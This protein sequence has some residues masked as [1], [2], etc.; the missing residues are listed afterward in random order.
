MNITW[1]GHNTWL[2][3]TGEHRLLIDPFFSDSPTAPV[4]AD[5]VEANFMLISHG[6]FDHVA[7]AAAIAKRTGCKVLAAFEIATWLGRQGVD[8][9]KLVG[10]NQGGGVDMPFGR[11][12]QT[13][14][15]HSSSLPDGSYAGAAAGWLLELL[16]KR[17]YF[18]CDTALFGDMQRI[19]AAGLDLAV[20]PIG[21]RFT[22]GPADS[23]EATRLLLPAK[24][25]PCH[26]NTWPPIAQDAEAWAEDIRR[27]T[28][29]EP[30][31][32]EPGESFAL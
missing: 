20:L 2:I 1:Y 25:A 14:A 31:V 30:V 10:M 15:F 16:G 17:L 11:A 6:H 32:L 27:Q 8:E 7:D 26:Y 23:I 9:A 22:M 3:E 28:T 12:T 24:V 19:G 13:V 29:A 18:A 21:D 4:K 5:E